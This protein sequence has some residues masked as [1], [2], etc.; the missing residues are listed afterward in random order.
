MSDAYA[1]DVDDPGVPNGE[2]ESWQAV[3]ERRQA[4]M[5]P[6]DTAYGTLAW[7]TGAAWAAGGLGATLHVAVGL[8]VG[9]GVYTAA[10]W[11]LWRSSDPHP[12]AGGGSGE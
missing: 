8:V 5:I 6:R 2:G 9:V 3:A 4:P 12:H 1:V 7:A 10:L 11:W